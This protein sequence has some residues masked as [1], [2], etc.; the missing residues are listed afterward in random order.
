[1]DFLTRAA[2]DLNEIDNS[3]PT[4]AWTKAE[5]VDYLNYAERDFLK[6]TGIVKTDVSVTLAAGSTILCDRPANT[7]NIDRISFNKKP[8]RRQTSHDLELEDRN[9]R[10]NSVGNPSYWHEDHLSN[11]KYELDKIPSAGGIIRII[12]DYLFDPY[13]SSFENMHLRDCWEPYLRWKV[14]SLALSKDGENKDTGRSQYANDR[15]L[16]GVRMARRLI[17]ETADI[18]IQR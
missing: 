16:L 7:M 5:M 13:A 10:V 6:K 9:W 18:N 1:M 2:V 11:S 3:F 4:G 12:G 14:I 17:T 15:Y 8:L